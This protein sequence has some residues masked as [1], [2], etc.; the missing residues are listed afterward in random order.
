MKNL[1]FFIIIVTFSS[2]K[3]YR[4][5]YAASPPCN[6]VFKAKGQSMLAGYYSRKNIKNDAHPQKSEGTDLQAAYAF[7]NHIAATFTYFQRNEKDYFKNENYQGTSN[8]IGQNYNR[9]IAEFGIGYFV[10]I[11][12]KKTIILN[13][14]TGVGFGKFYFND[15]ST[16]GKYNRFFAN[17]ITRLYFTPSINF[18]R[19]K[20][21]SYGFSFKT[22]FINYKNINTT[23]TA[24]ELNNLSLDRLKKRIFSEPACYIQLSPRKYTWLSLKV[25]GSLASDVSPEEIPSLEVNPSN[26]SFGLSFDVVKMYKS[27]RK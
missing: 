22:S 9:K 23:Y 24:Y 8:G 15:Y 11:N 4:L 16:D 19:K 7:T 2:C 12:E 1:L 5:I 25:I 18:M 27:F 13:L 10:F 14:Y 3:T 17:D 26:L 6:P 20:N 21:F